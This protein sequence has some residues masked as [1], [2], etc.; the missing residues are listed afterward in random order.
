MSG[1]NKAYESF[2][3]DIN[4]MLKRDDSLWKRRVT[5]FSPYSTNQWSFVWRDDNNIPRGYFIYKLEIINGERTM[6]VR[7][8]GFDSPDALC[9]MLA[10]LHTFASR[11][12]YAQIP[13]PE[14]IPLD[15]IIGEPCFGHISRTVEYTGML[16]VIN[17]KKALRN[18]RY[19]GSGRFVISVTDENIDNNN[20]F[21]A[22]Q[23]TPDGAEVTI[24]DEA[25]DIE[26]TIQGLSRLISGSITL[27]Q[28]QYYSGIT[29]NSNTETLKKAFYKKPLWIND[30]F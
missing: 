11:Y 19:D 4:F 16:R 20:G 29:I 26:T 27:E 22:V 15:G 21:F 17:V 7:D 25:P 14:H 24:T 8:L 30:Y 3:K 12:D 2:A 18:A 28:A 23:F 10:F 6:V 9:S 5:G 13:L 1:F